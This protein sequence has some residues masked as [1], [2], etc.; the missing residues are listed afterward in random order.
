[1]KIETER[2]IKTA[3]L[4]YFMYRASSLTD[5]R[6]VSNLIGIALFDKDKWESFASSIIEREEIEQTIEAAQ[7]VCANIEEYILQALNTDDRELKPS[8]ELVSGYM[9]IRDKLMHYISLKER[10]S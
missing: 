2:S 5:E 4:T 3:V 1:M 9:K 10:K 7:K 8:K 6:I